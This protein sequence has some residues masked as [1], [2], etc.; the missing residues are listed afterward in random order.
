MWEIRPQEASR[1]PGVVLQHCLTGL[2]RESFLLSGNSV[3]V[4]LAVTADQS[5]ASAKLD[6]K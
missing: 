1:F 5:L 2:S 4:C 6:V 3:V